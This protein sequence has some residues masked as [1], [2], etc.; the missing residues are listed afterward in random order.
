MIQEVILAFDLGVTGAPETFLIFNK[1]VIGHIQGELN[2]EKWQ[3]TFVPLI[4]AGNKR[5]NQMK[6]YFLFCP[7]YSAIDIFDG[8]LSSRLLPSINLKIQ[9]KKKD[10][11]H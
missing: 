10:F 3:S 7:I 4:N 1:Q 11:T 5:G 2:Q 6:S 9:F 8:Y